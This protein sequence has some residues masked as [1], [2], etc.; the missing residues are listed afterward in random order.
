VLD[1]RLHNGLGFD[2][3]HL[4]VVGQAS[5]GL[6][7]FACGDHVQVHADGQ[8]GRLDVDLSAGTLNNNCGRSPRFKQ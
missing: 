5:L 7:V 2:E 4:F 1:E 8:R 3:V 6:C